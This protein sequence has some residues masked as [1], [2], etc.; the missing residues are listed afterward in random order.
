MKTILREAAR[1]LVVKAPGDKDRN[2]QWQFRGDRKSVITETEI[3][4]E[5]WNTRTE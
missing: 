2:T 1:T 4:Y 3:Y 5:V